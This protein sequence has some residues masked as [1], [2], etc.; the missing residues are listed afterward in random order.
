MLQSLCVLLMR[1]RMNRIGIV[2]NI[3]KA[4]LQV[5]LQVE[6]RNAIR[7]FW[8]KDTS[9]LS[10]DTNIEVNRFC[11]VRFFWQR[12]LVITNQPTIVK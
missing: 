8:L 5:G 12:L 10:T 9:L 7:F 2:A 4:F 1:F 6:D 11:R 3:E